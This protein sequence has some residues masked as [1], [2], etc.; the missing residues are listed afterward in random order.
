MRVAVDALPLL[1][2]STGIAQYT[3]EL[4]RR[5]GR[6]ADVELFF[7]YGLYWGRELREKP[8][9][10][11]DNLRTSAR[12]A[13]PST[14]ALYRLVR[15]AVFSAGVLRRRIDLHHA[16]NFLP[17]RFSGPIVITVHDL[18][19]L[20]YPETHPED[21]VRHMNKFLPSAIERASFILVDSEF[22][23]QEVLSQFSISEE[24]VVTT[25][26][27]V[28]ERFRAMPSEHT[29]AVLAKHKLARGGYI[30][31]V[32]TLEPR[33]NLLR[34][35]EAY[36]SLPPATRKAFPLALVGTAGWRME[37]MQD[38]LTALVRSG[39][40]RLL[41][42]VAQEELPALYAGAAAFVYPS[43]YEGFGLPVLEALAS[44]APTVTSNR[45]ALLEIA[46]DAAV[47]VE[48][49]DPLAIRQ[50]LEAVLEPS[51]ERDKRVARGVAWARTFTWERCAEQTIQ[52]YR[53][54]VGQA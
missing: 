46:G 13:I 31:S 52:V 11:F 32:G 54:A 23:R 44:G 10:Y 51:P 50:G 33:K 25:L 4:M 37:A 9:P 35:L 12:A 48:P 22:V 49:E 43:L 36:G 5:V 34:T 15:Q 19:F 7:C 30:L 17:S 45:G 21:R 16:P 40:V 1:T 53:R 14:R 38:R 20:K 24:K 47:T 2:P 18:S 42:Y 41:G 3:R 26:L 6:T 27:G 8:L 28:S 29:A 39:D